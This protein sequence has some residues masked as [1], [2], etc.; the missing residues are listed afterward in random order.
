[1]SATHRMPFSDVGAPRPAVLLDT[2][3][4]DQV[5]SVNGRRYRTFVSR[6]ILPPPPGGYPVVYLLDANGMI[7]TVVEQATLR[8]LMGEIRPAVILGIGYP[9]DSR[10]EALGMRMFDLTPPTPPD[11]IP[12]SMAGAETGGSSAFLDFIIDELAPWIVSDFSGDA[13]EQ[14]LLGF[15]LGGLCVLTALFGRPHAFKTFVAGS[16][17][18][19][20]NDCGLLAQEPTFVEKVKAGDLGVR[21]LLTTGGLEQAEENLPAV[22]GMSIEERVALIRSA[23]MRDN[24]RELAARLLAALPSQ[25]SEIQFVEFEGETH[26][27]VIPATL[28]RGLGFALGAA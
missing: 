8:A 19:W 27:G 5:G 7:G 12:P 18:I 4:W 17:S 6:P 14:T 21:L 13:A 24:A 20:W 11:R 22:P 16:P 3:E 28:S 25:T 23:R 1:M 9:V 15:S 2:V 10:L 26:V